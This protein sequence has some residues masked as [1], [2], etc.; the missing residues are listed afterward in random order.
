MERRLDSTPTVE[1]PASLEAEQAALGGLLL[2]AHAGDLENLGR[3]EFLGQAHFSVPQ[4]AAIFR[5]IEAVYQQGQVP[6]L[7]TVTD[8]LRQQ[9]ALDDAGSATYITSL[10]TATYSP[11]TLPQHIAILKRDADRRAL[12]ELKVRHSSPPQL[13]SVTMCVGE[14][15]GL[16]RPC[17]R[18]PDAPHGKA[19]ECERV[20]LFYLRRRPS[21]SSCVV[22]SYEYSTKRLGSLAM[23]LT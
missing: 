6:D 10:L 2:A 5:A 14:P 15:T 7:V 11:A 22:V 21:G 9:G 16:V 13:H 23:L 19:D 4:H 8:F 12:L 20:H 3:I 18:V 1:L 17:E